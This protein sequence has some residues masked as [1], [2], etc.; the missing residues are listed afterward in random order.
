MSNKNTDGVLIEPSTNSKVKIIENF[1]PSIVHEGVKNV[2]LGSNFPWYF[3]NT[4][5]DLDTIDKDS[6]TNFQFTHTFF[7]EHTV[8]SPN[9]WGL[10]APIIEYI[11]PISL[12]RIKANLTTAT[13]NINEHGW[14]VDYKRPDYD[15]S[16]HMI[17]IY[18][19]NSNNGKTILKN[20]TEINSVENRLAILNGDMLHTGT[21]CTD[22]KVRCVINFNYISAD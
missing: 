15:N 14:H 12:M 1:L 13:E 20:G 16:K 18:Y 2:L 6:I 22:E 9:Y 19:V 7:A 17:G 11:N 21:S 10:V 3:N 4:I 8:H 5:L